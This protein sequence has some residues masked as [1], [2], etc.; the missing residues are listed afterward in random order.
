[1]VLL[2]PLIFTLFLEEISQGFSDQFL[3]TVSPASVQKDSSTVQLR[4]DERDAQSDFSKNERPDIKVI[5]DS[6][7]GEIRIVCDIPG[8]DDG[9][10]TCFLSLGD[11]YLQY[12]KIASHK[13]SG[14]TQ[15][16]FTVLENEFPN[17][18]KS[19]E[20]KVMSC[21]YSPKNASSKGSYSEKFNITG[22]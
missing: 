18:L 13:L 9:G 17:R 19:V 16:L 20:N 4:H 3:L 5:H 6:Q 12:K 15:C 2:I 8:S 1:M 7:N 11:E 22:L 21:S 10:Y 14:K